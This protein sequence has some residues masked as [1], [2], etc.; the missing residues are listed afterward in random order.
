[1]IRCRP[2]IPL[3]LFVLIVGQELA[4]CPGS[5]AAAAQPPTTDAQ[6][7]PATQTPDTVALSQ[8]V[9]RLEGRLDGMEGRP[10]GSDVSPLGWPTAAAWL[11]T[12]IIA[13][14]AYLGTVRAGRQQAIETEKMKLRHSIADR[15][16]RVF[17]GAVAD[18]LGM[19][20]EMARQDS[21]TDA[22]RDAAERFRSV[23]PQ[24]GLQ[25]VLAADLAM[26]PAD[27]DAVTPLTKDILD[28]CKRVYS[29]FT[30][31]RKPEE[32]S[33]NLA[34]RIAMLVHLLMQAVDASTEARLD[35]LGLSGRCSRHIKRIVDRW[36]EETRAAGV[37]G[38]GGA[39]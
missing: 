28:S 38:P 26:R 5:H 22:V 8:R 20:L 36:D 21:D 37:S 25:V 3:G 1:M 29:Q 14:V 2:L 6:R 27:S 23:Y 16:L 30:Q 33:E 18:L 7:A 12:L 15:R 9:T 10:P 13:L 31:G 34:A 17:D 4:S 19:M 11:G 24:A 39:A 32:E 35:E